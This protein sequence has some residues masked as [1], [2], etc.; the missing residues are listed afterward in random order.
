MLDEVCKVT[1]WVIERGVL[2][3]CKQDKLYC[4]ALVLAMFYV[5]GDDGLL[6]T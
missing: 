3:T 6:D 1:G 4:K 5:V 2:G